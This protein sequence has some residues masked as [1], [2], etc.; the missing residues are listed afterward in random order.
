MGQLVPA[1]QSARRGCLEGEIYD[2]NVDADSIDHFVD[3]MLATGRVDRERI[4]V[5]GWSNPGR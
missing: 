1:V 2:E 3:E 4:Y 5:M